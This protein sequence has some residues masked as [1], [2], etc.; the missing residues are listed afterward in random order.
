MNCTRTLVGVEGA[1]SL[2]GHFVGDDLD[3]AVALHHLVFE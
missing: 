2:A 3:L 1:R